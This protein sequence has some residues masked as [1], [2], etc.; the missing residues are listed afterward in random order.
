MHPGVLSLDG[1]QVAE[2]GADS[3][4]QLGLVVE[5]ASLSDRLRSRRVR[6]D[7]A[8]QASQSDLA[9]H[10]DRQLAA[11]IKNARNET[12]GVCLITFVMHVVHR[13]GSPSNP[14]D[15]SEL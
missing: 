15:M 4:R 8:R 10:S 6:V 9:L 12:T 14:P 7:H 1:H 2:Q 3:R 11:E 13:Y 5:V